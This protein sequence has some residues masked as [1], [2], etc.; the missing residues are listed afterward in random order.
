MWANQEEGTEPAALPNC[1]WPPAGIA[2]KESQPA[3]TT[4]RS[5]DCPAPN[6]VPDADWD[7]GNIGCGELVMGLRMRLQSMKP[8][9]VLR[10][11]A[12]DAGIPEDLPAWCHLTGHQLIYASHPKYWLQRR[13]N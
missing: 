1:L 9:Q 12:T 13:E 4:V 6:S 7:A 8:G 2:G 5:A 3:Q 10:L 11:T